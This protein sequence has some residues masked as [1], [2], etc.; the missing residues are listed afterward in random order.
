[1][2][3]KT[4]TVLAIA[5]S[6][7]VM[8]QTVEEAAYDYATHKTKFR[9]DVLKEVESDNYISRKSDCM[10]DFQCGAI[11]QL[12]QNTWIK[13]AE[14][15]PIP[16]IEARIGDEEEYGSIFVVG[17]SSQWKIPYI[18]CYYGYNGNYKWEDSIVPEFWMPIPEV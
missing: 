7:I 18:C 6:K 8:K 11:W 5:H 9:K 2:K 15:L 3:K 1:M 13:T 16:I 10:E 12:K 4:V 14:R 17:R